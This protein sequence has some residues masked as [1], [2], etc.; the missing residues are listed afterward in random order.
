MI[1]KNIIN[2]DAPIY[3]CPTKDNAYVDIDI[4][5]TFRLPQVE[6]LVKKF[7][8][9]LG[10]GRFDELLAAECEENIRNFINSVWLS[11]IFDLKSDMAIAMMTELNRK[12]AQYG[13]VFEQCNV[14]NVKVNENLIKALTEKTKIKFEL[15]NHIKDQENKKLVLE[16]EEQQ[17]LTDL[18]RNNERK[19]FELKQSI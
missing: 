10:A 9:Q 18:Q 1:T 19:M 12:F 6:I 4:H 2:Y 3:R 17:N 13:I 16:N 11:Q 5:F 15:K 8:Y 14:T 7:V